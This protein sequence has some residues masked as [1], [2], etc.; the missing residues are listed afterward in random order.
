MYRRRP[1]ADQNKT[2]KKQ[3]ATEAGGQASPCQVQKEQLHKRAQPGTIATNR[4]KP[5]P[6]TTYIAQVCTMLHNKLIFSK[7]QF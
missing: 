2:G 7:R 1:E 5:A 6:V 4:V 3:W